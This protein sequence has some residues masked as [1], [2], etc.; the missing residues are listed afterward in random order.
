[1]ASYSKLHCLENKQ[2]PGLYLCIP[3]IYSYTTSY[4]LTKGLYFLHAHR[5][6]SNVLYPKAHY[7]NVAVKS[8]T[9]VLLVA[10][11]L[12]TVG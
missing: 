3:L 4:I 12:V 11:R 2:R 9:Y 6:Y 8:A 10:E 1:M 7:E 5:A